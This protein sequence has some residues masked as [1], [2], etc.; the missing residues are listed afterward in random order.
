M[1]LRDRVPAS[2]CTADWASNLPCSYVTVCQLH[3]RI[4]ERRLSLFIAF[5]LKSNAR[6]N[7]WWQMFCWRRKCVISCVMWCCCVCD[8]VLLCVVVLLCFL[9]Y[10]PNQPHLLNKYQI[11]M[12]FSHFHEFGILSGMYILAPYQ[13]DIVKGCG[14]AIAI[15]Y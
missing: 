8:V 4:S 11:N 6:A 12:G 13:I 15:L 7:F 1:Q 2:F 3:S 5:K 14:S 9:W 10:C